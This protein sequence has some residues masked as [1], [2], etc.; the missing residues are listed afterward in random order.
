MSS[1][2]I[3]MF[4]LLFFYCIILMQSNLLIH[5]R[6]SLTLT[7]L[8]HFISCVQT[9]S[10]ITTCTDASWTTNSPVT[11]TNTHSVCSLTLFVTS[12]WDKIC[13]FVW[14]TNYLFAKMCQDVC[15]CVLSAS[16]T[17]ATELKASYQLPPITPPAL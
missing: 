6:S 4:L 12:H 11:L 16:V 1:D 8:T 10:A 15:V 3:Q 13:Y 14:L 17:S 9:H 5:E 2:C 7:L